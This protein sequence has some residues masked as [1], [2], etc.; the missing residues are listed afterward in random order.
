MGIF[1]KLRKKATAA[2]FGS[3]DQIVRVQAPTLLDLL[4]AADERDTLRARVAELERERDEARAEM[5]RQQALAADAINRLHYADAENRRAADKWRDLATGVELARIEGTAM[6]LRVPHWAA[7]DL[8]ASFYDSFIDTD[9]KNWIEL[10]FKSDDPKHA[11]IGAIVVTIQRVDG[12]TQGAMLAEAKVENDTLRTARDLHASR[13]AA[14]MDLLTAARKENAG[15]RAARGVREGDSRASRARATRNLPKTTTRTSP[16]PPCRT[17]VG[18]DDAEAATPARREG[19]ATRQGVQRG[20]SGAS[21]VRVLV[22]PSPLVPTPSNAPTASPPR[23]RPCGGSGTRRGT[24]WRSIAEG[25]MRWL[26]S[27]IRSRSP[28]PPNAPA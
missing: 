4:D 3:G 23:T 2:T 8:A 5:K 25:S 10:P 18:R 24:T 14:N 6:Y 27:S 22:G 13:E 15:L 9:S 12:K 26:P 19:R 20:P 16:A 11:G 21:R 1:D 28:A 7:H 17:E